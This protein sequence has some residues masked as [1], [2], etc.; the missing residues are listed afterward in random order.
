ML[1]RREGSTSIGHTLEQ[2]LGLTENNLAIPDI[3]GRVELK[4]T[5]KNSSSL[6]TLFAFNKAVWRIHPKEVIE[7]YGYIDEKSRQALQ[8]RVSCS[9]YN[10]RNLKIE[11]DKI[12]HKV[13]LYSNTEDLLATWNIYTIV[14]K[15]I[16]KFEKL[17]IVFA[18]TRRVH[19]KESFLFNEAY[20]LKEPLPECFL[21]AFE[22]SQIVIELRMYLK[23]TG[24]VRN[25]GTAFRIK[26]S[27]IIHL[28]KDKQQIL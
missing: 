6:I 20:L 18:D 16:S 8:S 10:S 22:N 23:N 11:L 21:R 12:D 5:R 27:D 7:K 9:R 2:E 3:S 24:S 15:F 1:S 14:G 26:E 19:G 17:L 13:H 4:A 25:H 28:Y